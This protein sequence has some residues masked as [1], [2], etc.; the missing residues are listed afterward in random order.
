MADKDNKQNQNQQPVNFNVDPTRVPV[1]Y[2]D[3]YLIGSSQH[4]VTLNFAQAVLDGKQQNIVARIALTP[5]QTKELLQ[6]LN[7]HIEKFEI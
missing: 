7:D 4:A 2:A 5:A 3:A 1:L 6:T